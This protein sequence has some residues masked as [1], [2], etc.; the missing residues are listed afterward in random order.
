MRVT[1]TIRVDGKI[2]SKR[3]YE[4]VAGLGANVTDMGDYTMLHG[5]GTPQQASEAVLFT[6]LF[7]KTTAEIDE[8][9]DEA[10]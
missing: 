5:D 2:D 6:S 4:L 7:G 8:I 3:L 9:A 10:P 1:Y